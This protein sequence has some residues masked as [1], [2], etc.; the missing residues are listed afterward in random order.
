M[1]GTV[2]V[3][4]GDTPFVPT[5][6]VVGPT[7]YTPGQTVT[8]QVTNGPG[9]LGDWVGLYATTV[10]DVGFLSWTYL[11]GTTTLPETG[12]TTATITFTLPNTPGTY[13]CRL[14]QAGG[15]TKLA[16][17]LTLRVQ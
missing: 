2:L 17:S 16:T 3:S 8:I 10:G 5:L 4:W 14:F 6:T 9:N 15:Y 1:P 11:S 13:N 7:I 12:L